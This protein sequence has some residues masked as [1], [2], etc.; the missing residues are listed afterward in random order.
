MMRIME[1]PLRII[2]VSCVCLL[3]LAG[4]GIGAEPNDAGTD[5]PVVKAAVIVCKG[6]IDDG[7]YRS[8]QRRTQMALDQDVEY[9]IYEIE[10]YGGL[11]QSALDISEYFILDIPLDML[12]VSGYNKFYL[13]KE[14]SKY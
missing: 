2:A 11:V 4:P 1:S 9:L 14:F 7:L 10:T 3:L 13:N 8:I 12:I 5:F 6:M